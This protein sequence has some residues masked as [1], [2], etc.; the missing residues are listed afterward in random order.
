MSADDTV[1]NESSKRKKTLKPQELSTFCSQLALIVRSGI[2]IAEGLPLLII[3]EE[4]S[5]DLNRA[6]TIVNNY[7]QNHEFFYIALEKSGYFPNYMVQMVHIGETS[8]NIDEIME[9]LSKYYTREE[10]LKHRIRNAVTYPTTLIVLMSL[11]VLFLIAKVLPLFEDILI[12]LGN[13][14]PYSVKLIMQVSNFLSYN[15]VAILLLFIFIYIA[16]FFWNRSSRGSYINDSLKM[17]LPGFKHIYELIYSERFANAMAFLL[18][19]GINLDTSLELS[20]SILDNAKM[21][22]KIS[23]CQNLLMSGNTLSEAL[24]ESKCFPLL[25]T[26]MLG[27][28]AKT[29]NL[30][31]MMADLASIY[32]KKVNS[33]LKTATSVIE[34]SLVI[35]LS[36]IVGIILVSIMLPLLDIMSTIG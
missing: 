5:T 4:A 35:A 25:F 30:S 29:G 24:Y 32:E 23:H 9:S 19:A 33:S 18:E 17:I 12:S 10:N 21:E 8:G 22:K 28:S 15:W 36:I 26:R 11:V 27:I 2:P 13:Q 20:K 1:A 6:A 7:V 16:A 3:E 31:K 14:M 34:P